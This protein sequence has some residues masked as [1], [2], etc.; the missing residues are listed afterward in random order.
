MDKKKVIMFVAVTYAIAWIIA[1]PASIYY[2][3]NPGMGGTSVFKVAAMIMMFA[4]LVSVFITTRD[5]KVVN[6]KPKFK[7][8]VKWIIFA[9]IIPAVVVAAGA[10]LFYIIFPDLFDTTGSYLT[11][12]GEDMGVDLMAQLESMGLTLN[13]YVAF[14]SLSIFLY[15]GLINMLFAVGEE[16]GWRG[17]LYPEL[18]KK[19]GRIKTWIIGG[20]IWSVFHFP[21]M[22]IA[23]YEYGTDYL[24]APILGLIVFTVN[25]I[26]N[27]I[28][29]EIIYDKTKCIWYPALF[30]GV[31]NAFAN[32][33]FNY[34]NVNS[35]GK[36]ERLMILG[37]GVNGII[38][39]IPMV[40][41]AVIVA[42][43]VIKKDKVENKLENNSI[44]G[45]DK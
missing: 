33:P 12:S 4:P 17:F 2:K 37:P 14:S 29:N 42:V 40:I 5:L 44:E 13:M 18:K 24:G 22:L 31:F 41:I 1:I 7:G 8:N 3:K 20:A 30:H 28:F 34:W 19:Y 39:M 32:I 26:F 21:I 6:W 38:G 35:D 25:C 43:I 11:K 16:A 27:G 36:A 10:V 9:F 45:G 23:G 15:G